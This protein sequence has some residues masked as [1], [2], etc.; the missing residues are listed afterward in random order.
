MKF[1]EVAVGEKFIHNNQEYIKTPEMRVS[2]CKIKDNCQILT[3][4]QKA[5]LKPLDEVEKVQ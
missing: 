3:T 2:C 1:H 4:G 5:V